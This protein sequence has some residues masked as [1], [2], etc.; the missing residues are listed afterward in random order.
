MSTYA[1]RTRILSLH[2]TRTLVRVYITPLNMDDDP[3]G[4]ISSPDYER[5]AIAIYVT[6][7]NTIGLPLNH[8][9][10]SVHQ[11]SFLDGRIGSAALDRATECVNL[12]RDPQP[13]NTF[14]YLIESL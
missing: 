13:T 2:K 1:L 6:A 8:P 3:S 12:P 10:E 11:V 14:L 9:S 5:D 7:N 4:C